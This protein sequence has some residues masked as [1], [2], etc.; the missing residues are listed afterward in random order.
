MANN[1]YGLDWLP[2]LSHRKADVYVAL[3]DAIGDDIKRGRLKAGAKLPP[4]RLLAYTLGLNLG[5]VHK[6]YRLA[7]KR[8]LVSGEV[9]RGSFVRGDAASNADWPNEDP[10]SRM[11]DFCDNFPCPIRKVALVQKQLEVLSKTSNLG[12]LLQYQQNSAWANHKHIA[13]TWLGRFGVSATPSTTLI[14]NGALHAGFISL[15]TLCR[16][17][18]T[19]L[20]EDMTSQAIKGAARRLKLRLK[21][22]KTDDKGIIPEHL[23]E[24]LRKERVSAVYLVPTLHNPTSTLLPLG[25]RRK[26][27]A[28]LAH[29]GVP[30]IEDDIFAPLLDEVP[31]PISALIPDLG[32]YIAGLSK[33]LA[34]SLRL[35]FL[36]VPERHYTDALDCLRLTS[37]YASPLLMELAGNLI[38][39][40]DAD[41]LIGEQRREINKRQEAA[42]NA[43]RGHGL[44]AAHPCALHGW[45]KLLDPWRA[46]QF[47]ET[48]REAGVLVQ[49]A[50]AFAVERSQAVHAVRLC[51]GTPG[52]FTKVTEGLQMIS[53]VLRRRL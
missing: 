25:R 43:F 19:V 20:T 11:I 32:F 38:T 33:A 1:P 34:P 30:L 49:S 10:C 48:L 45:L 51:L 31:T 37:W 52:S 14:A 40:G 36:K 9:G 26:V 17:G 47:T 29:H 3:A 23:D 41:R 18:D 53:D 13:A 22:I 7:T 16:A 46:T 6:A 2:D 50:E 24:L 5:T 8:G 39:S 35:A 12:Q 44:Y 27:A 28:I 4:Q 42:R 21:G 15:L